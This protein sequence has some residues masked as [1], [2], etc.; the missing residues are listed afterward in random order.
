MKQLFT[1]CVILHT[2]DTNE[3][4]EKKYKDSELIIKPNDILAKNEKEVLF[5]VTREIPEKYASNPDDIAILV[6]GF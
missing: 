5:K 3:K 2:Y 1:Y 4:G 6:R